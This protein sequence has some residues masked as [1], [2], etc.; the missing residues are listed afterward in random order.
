MDKLPVGKT[1][2]T[3]RLYLNGYS[4]SEIAAKVGVSKST[5]G[6]VIS[7]LKAGKFPEVG[8]IREQIELFHELGL[9]LKRCNM[10]VGQAAVGA[11]ALSRFHEMGLE[12]SDLERVKDN[13]SKKCGPIS[14]LHC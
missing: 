1:K 9:E 10:T 13:S 5:V 7:D 6:N 11:A 4:Y 8:D 2:A 3:I 12:P 14:G